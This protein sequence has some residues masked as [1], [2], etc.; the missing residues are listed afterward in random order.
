MS[1]AEINANK[2]KFAGCPRSS[3]A[4]VAR[5]LYTFNVPG[6]LSLDRSSECGDIASYFH[7]PTCM[8]IIFDDEGEHGDDHDDYGALR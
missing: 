4:S 8:I 6:P 1:R 5:F 7:I 3:H 2:N